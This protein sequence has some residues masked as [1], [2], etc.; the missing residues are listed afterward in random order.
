MTATEKKQPEQ[1]ADLKLP[2]LE[3][4]E[5]EVHLYQLHD[6]KT[7]RHEKKNNI[8]IPISTLMLHGKSF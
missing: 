6:R 2:S 4:N 8:K 7:G 1:E 3:G 5:I